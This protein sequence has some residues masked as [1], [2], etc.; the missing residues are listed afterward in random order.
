MFPV[1]ESN[2]KFAAAG[3]PP[4]GGVIWKSDVEFPTV[5]VGRPPGILTVCG[6]ALRRIVPAP[7]GSMMV[8]VVLVLLL[9]THEALV[10]RT[11][12]PQGLTSS[13]SRT[14]A[15]PGISDSRVVSL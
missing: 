2:M 14:G 1:I 5:A 3:E 9:A 13:G 7:F 4:P 15:S 12:N 8:C 10:P 6:V 11:V